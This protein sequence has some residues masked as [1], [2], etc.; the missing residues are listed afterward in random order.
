M[1]DEFR[2]LS[3]KE[4][5]IMHILW[6]TGGSTVQEVRNLLRGKPAYTT[7]QTILN[8]MDRK[9]SATRI[10]IGRAY[11][12]RATIS[13][14]AFLGWALKDFVQRTFQGSFSMMMKIMI[15]NKLLTLEQEKAARAAASAGKGK[16]SACISSRQRALCVARR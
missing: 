6:E 9:G 16:Q 5:E 4:L 7:V 10:L 11:V 2:P 15:E 14:D 13:R 8:I 3:P 12:Y 1:I